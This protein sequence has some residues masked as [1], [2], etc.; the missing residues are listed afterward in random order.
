MI[1][2]SDGLLSSLRPKPSLHHSE[3]AVPFAGKLQEIHLN[4]GVEKVL[5]GS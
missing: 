5:Q 3:S 2:C 1:H 4:T